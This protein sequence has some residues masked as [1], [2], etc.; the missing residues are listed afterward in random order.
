MTQN[1]FINGKMAEHPM[2]PQC[3]LDVAYQPTAR[4]GQKHFITGNIRFV[5]MA[6]NLLQGTQRDEA[7]NAMDAG[8]VM[9]IGVEWEDVETIWRSFMEVEHGI[10]PEKNHTEQLVVEDQLLYACPRCGPSCLL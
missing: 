5:L 4:G 3:I 2:T 9:T 1:S 10:W 6:R 7:L 8:T